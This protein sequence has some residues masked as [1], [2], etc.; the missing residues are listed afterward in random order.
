MRGGK[1]DEFELVGVTT[2]GCAAAVAVAI[3]GTT[4]GLLLLLCIKLATSCIGPK[5]EPCSLP[6]GDTANAV[7]MV[8]IKSKLMAAMLITHLRPLGGRTVRE[9]F[10][11]P[12]RITTGWR[13]DVVVLLV[14]RGVKVPVRIPGKPRVTL[15]DIVCPGKLPVVAA[16]VPGFGNGPE[17][18]GSLVSPKSRVRLMGSG[19]S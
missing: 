5:A 12:A 7:P 14:E 9:P 10:L 18:A 8:I 16:E 4:L 13:N 15:G 3:C 19:V 17:T 11:V 1:V 6:S 2:S